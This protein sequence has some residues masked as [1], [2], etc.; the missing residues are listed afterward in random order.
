[1]SQN[2]CPRWC[3]EHIYLNAA[4]LDA[5]PL[6]RST[7]ADLAISGS[8]LAQVS[9]MVRV[10]LEG[11]YTSEGLLDEWADLNIAGNGTELTA[12]EL[13]SLARLLD[14]AADRLEGAR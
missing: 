10:Q 9:A 8:N 11:A 6:H 14:E 3:S 7:P 13:R 5:E 1:M 2:P 4:D 12:V